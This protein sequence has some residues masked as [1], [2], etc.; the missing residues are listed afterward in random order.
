[1]SNRILIV[2]YDLDHL[3]ETKIYLES[4]EHEVMTATNGDIALKAFEQEKPDLVLMSAM[5]PKK[6][7]FEVCREIHEK[8]PKTPIILL[9]EIYK[10]TQ[11]R[12]QALNECGASAFLELPLAMEQILEQVDSLLAG[13]PAAGGK[14]RPAQPK[15]AESPEGTQSSPGDEPEGQPALLSV[16]DDAT[17]NP[18]R[19]TLGPQPRFSGGLSADQLFQKIKRSA[20]APASLLDEEPL[21]SPL[22]ELGLEEELQD[23]ISALGESI[24]EREEPAPSPPQ[25][26]FETSE[27]AEIPPPFPLKP[28]KPRRRGDVD[29]LVEQRLRSLMA[30]TNLSSQ[31]KVPDPVAEPLPRFNVPERPASSSRLSAP[32]LPEPSPLAATPTPREAATLREQSGD[33]IDAMLKGESIFSKPVRVGIAIGSVLLFGALFFRI[34]AP[35]SSSGDSGKPADEVSGNPSH[36]SSIIES[37]GEPQTDRGERPREKSAGTAPPPESSTDQGRAGDDIPLSEEDE[38]LFFPGSWPEQVDPDEAKLPTEP[39][40]DPLNQQGEEEPKVDERHEF[41]ECYGG[42]ERIDL[43]AGV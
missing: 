4:H 25:K 36:S 37:P 39:A 38:D 22:N 40:P 34:L 35:F 28:R 8:N 24:E 5:L 43:H 3:A 10:G 18:T 6:N 13:S 11:Y 17:E 41:V 16:A 27:S 2:D 29:E 20:E 15:P 12:H 7:G 30:G 9:S 21:V 32:E 31:E 23:A 1:M 19:D 26:L 33:P 14:G 42:D